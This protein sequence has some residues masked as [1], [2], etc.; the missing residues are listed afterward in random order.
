MLPHPGPVTGQPIRAVDGLWFKCARCFVPLGAGLL[1][2]AA[3]GAPVTLY[4]PLFSRY[5]LE[6]D[7]RV[8]SP[9]SRRKRC[10]VRL[11]RYPPQQFVVARG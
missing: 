8:H 9:V 2:C 11:T 7:A 4:E 6:C 3:T 1:A 10:F 5:R